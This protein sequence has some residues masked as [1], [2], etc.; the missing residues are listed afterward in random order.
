MSRFTRSLPVWSFQIRNFSLIAWW[1]SRRRL[2]LGMVLICGFGALRI[3]LESALDDEWRQRNL[4]PVRLDSGV[5]ERLGQMSF[6]A[7]L[8]GFRSL[9]ASYLSLEAYT[10]WEDV[11]WAKLESTYDL[12]TV[13]QPQVAAYWEEY[14]W[15]MAYNARGYYLY[16][17]KTRVA[18]RHHLAA[19]YLEKG[20][21]VLREGI[22]HNPE[23]YL[24]YVRL[25]E[26]LR[27]KEGDHCSA[28]DLL[29]V[30]A[31]LDT[32]PDYL[33]RFAAYELSQCPG[34]EREAYEALLKLYREG[35]DHHKP[36]LLARLSAME[37]R[38]GIAPEKR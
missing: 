35:A 30:A 7:A 6:V 22:R 9:V 32:A 29:Q 31:L 21:A 34:R 1:K 23:D 24:L 2:L 33:R 36:T 14:G 5:R 16:D 15:H 18:L 20:K 37:T 4:L 10:A 25:G 27:S 8:G 38:L 17:S 13:L 26:V 11:D 3:P 19:S 12:I 28:A